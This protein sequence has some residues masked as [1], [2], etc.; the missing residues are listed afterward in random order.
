MIKIIKMIVIGIQIG[1]NIHHQDQVATT[2]HPPSLSVKKIKN[3][4]VP[5]P[6]PLELLF[7]FSIM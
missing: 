3:R 5:N 6:K 2:P 1:E 4:I 7:S